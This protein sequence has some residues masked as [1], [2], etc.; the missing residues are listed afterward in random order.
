MFFFNFL[1]I[2]VKSYFGKVLIVAYVTL[3]WNVLQVLD[4]CMGSP[5]RQEQ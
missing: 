1:E 5:S 4:N 2:G 3:A